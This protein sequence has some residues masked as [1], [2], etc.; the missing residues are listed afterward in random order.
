V[1]VKILSH[2]HFLGTLTG[3]HCDDFHG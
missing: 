1:C 2:A 3:E